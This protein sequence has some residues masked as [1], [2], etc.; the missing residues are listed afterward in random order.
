MLPFNADGPVMVPEFDF[1][2]YQK[3]PFPDFEHAYYFWCNENNS[4]GMRILCLR[5]LLRQW[6]TSQDISLISSTQN[7]PYAYH[8]YGIDF[9]AIL[10]VEGS[11]GRHFYWNLKNRPELFQEITNEWLYILQQKNY[12]PLNVETYQYRDRVITALLSA[13][14]EDAESVRNLWSFHSLNQPITFSYD[15][16]SVRLELLAANQKTLPNWLRTE[17]WSWLDLYVKQRSEQAFTG[18]NPSSPISL[19]TDHTN[20]YGF[21]SL[22]NF[23]R[24]MVDDMNPTMIASLIR[25]LETHLPDHVTYLNTTLLLKCTGTRCQIDKTSL[26]SCIHR[27]LLALD[28]EKQGRSFAT[29]SGHHFLYW[30][31]GVL[32]HTNPTDLVP[33]EKIDQLLNIEPT[34]LNLPIGA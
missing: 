19:S 21:Q 27:H 26:V 28:V 3:H 9:T 15:P 20:R 25:L 12:L 7:S 10:D 29:S 8:D 34:T 30:A 23:L 14:S 17:L 22:L 24:T 13:S 32:S 33:I 11:N 2:L 4:Y 16:L 5:D 6:H 1:E 18:T 31:R